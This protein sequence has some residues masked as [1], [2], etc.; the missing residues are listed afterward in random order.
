MGKITTREKRL[1]IKLADEAIDKSQIGNFVALCSLLST[2][3]DIMVRYANEHV[4][5]I[6]KTYGIETR[7]RYDTDCALTGMAK[8][9]KA[10]KELGYWYEKEVERHVI[11]ATYE[12]Y[13][14]EALDTF[15]QSANDLIKFMMGLVDRGKAPGVLDRIFEFIHDLPPQGRFDDEFISRFNLGEARTT[16][17]EEQK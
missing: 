2:A 9:A 8:M 12:S 7:L 13:G 3:L 16:E 4:A 5:G 17:Q 1:R 14:A 6:Y 15:H 11:D 10:G